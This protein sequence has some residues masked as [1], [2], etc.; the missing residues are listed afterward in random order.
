M[1]K[2]VVLDVDDTIVN[3]KKELSIASK[4]CIVAAQKKGI[5]VTLASGRMYQTMQS[6]AKNLSITIPLI[7]C[8][9]ALIRNE[10]RILNCENVDE[11]IAKKV[12][13]FFSER[14]KVLQLYTKQGLFTK[15]KCPCTWSLEEQEGL[16]CSLLD[17]KTYDAFNKD[18]LKLL[19]RL[20]PSEVCTYRKELKDSFGDKISAAL[21]HNVYIEITNKEVNKGR[22]VAWLAKYLGVEQKNVLAIGDSPND[23]SMLRWAGLGIAM[24]NA[25]DEVKSVADEITL[26][27]DDDGVAKVLEKYVL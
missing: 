17:E 1:F 24:G 13:T 3:S 4:E 7:S 8:N 15:E 10:E 18:L 6:T 11:N 27:V 22:A 25:S 9:G 26:S 12:M 23:T 14:N 21:S 5:Y 16:P 20:Y 2:L 19:I